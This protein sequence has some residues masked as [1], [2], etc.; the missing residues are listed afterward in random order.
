[1]QTDLTVDSLRE[2]IG[3]L[4]ASTDGP[5]SICPSR[6][7]VHPKTY[8]YFRS[9]QRPAIKGL[10]RRGAY[11]QKWAKSMMDQIMWDAINGKETAKA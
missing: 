5:I 9:I 10:H 7:L 1:M 8:D 2:A 6:I 11:R 4:R 3:I